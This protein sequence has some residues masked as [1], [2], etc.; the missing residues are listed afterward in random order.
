MMSIALHHSLSLHRL[1]GS[2]DP[3]TVQVYIHII[4]LLHSVKHAANHKVVLVEHVLWQRLFCRLAHK[5][6]AEGARMNGKHLM[7]SKG[8]GLAPSEYFARRQN[9]LIAYRS[10]TNAVGMNI[11]VVCD[12]KVDAAIIFALLKLVKECREI[13]AHHV[14]RVNHLEV[15]SRRVDKT[16]INALSVTAVLLMNNANDRWVLFSISISNLACA[17]L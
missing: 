15:L 1:I 2:A 14:V 16:L 11:K 12:H 3:I 5:L 7:H 4:H 17:V 8:L 6:G 10:V 9:S 13:L